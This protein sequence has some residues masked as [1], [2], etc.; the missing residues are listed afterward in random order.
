MQQTEPADATPARYSWGVQPQLLAAR[1]LRCD[2]LSSMPCR[3]LSKWLEHELP[4]LNATLT[5]APWAQPADAV[6]QFAMEQARNV[7]SMRP[8][9][10]LPN[11]PNRHLLAPSPTLASI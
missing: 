5:V 1:G 7:R 8:I 2:L 11:H 6:E 9:A 4:N 3:P 10:D